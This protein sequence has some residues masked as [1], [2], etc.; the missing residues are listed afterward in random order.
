MP[1]DLCLTRTLSRGQI[2][3]DGLWTNTTNPL[4]NQASME[5]SVDNPDAN[6]EPPPQTQHQPSQMLK[7]SQHHL[8]PK[9]CKTRTTPNQSKATPPLW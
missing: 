4:E 1:W 6:I 7:R 5:E 3:P 9:G 2:A 8:E